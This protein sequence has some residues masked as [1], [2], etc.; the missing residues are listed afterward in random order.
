MS[1]KNALFSLIIDV[2]VYCVQGVK[3]KNEN[4]KLKIKNK[5]TKKDTKKVKKKIQI[6]AKKKTGGIS[7]V[8]VSFSLSGVCVCVCDI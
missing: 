6:K 7:N 1:D 3:S 5:Q 8:Y 4:K 2:C